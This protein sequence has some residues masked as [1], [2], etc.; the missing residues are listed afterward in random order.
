MHHHLYP[1]KDT[2]ISNRPGFADKNFGIDEIL[3]IGTSNVIIRS[4]ATTKDYSYVEAIFNNYPVQYFTGIFT[5][6]LRGTV[7]SLDGNLVG[8]ALLFT[9]S[10]FS[11][12]VDGG[13]IAEYSGSFRK[14]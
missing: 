1:Q 9:A 5:G 12:S 10:Y 3:Q 2:F 6:S 7:S 14:S 8:S 13:A 11:G 4:L